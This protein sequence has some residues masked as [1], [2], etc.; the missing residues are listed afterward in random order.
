[1]T[2]GHL[3]LGLPRVRQCAFR[4]DGDERIEALVETRDPFEAGARQLYRRERPRAD[5]P[6]CFLEVE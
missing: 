2:L 3:G 1:M 5:R 4:G 6:G